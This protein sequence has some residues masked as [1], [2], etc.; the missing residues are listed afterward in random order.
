MLNGKLPYYRRAYR[1]VIEGSDRIIVH[2]PDMA[3][4]IHFYAKKR[5][6]PDYVYVERYPCFNARPPITDIGEAK[7]V[8]GVQDK[9]VLLAPGDQDVSTVIDALAR[10]P[11]E[12]VAV[13]AGAERRKTGG[14]V[15]H[16]GHVPPEHVSLVYGAADAVVFTRPEPGA[17]HA[18]LPYLKPVIVPDSPFSAEVEARY[19]AVLTYEGAGS[20]ALAVDAAIEH[21]QR[22]PIVE[23]ARKY[24]REVDAAT[25]A[26]HL[27][28]G[29]E[30]LLE[31]K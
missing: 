26:A 15:I 14:R 28:E 10:L 18:A 3:R 20:L 27:K 4:R 24:L 5:G 8:L 29:Y 16:L 31:M 17:V 9:K 25:L 23:G 13:F 22:R 21:H 7:T 11:D 1:S 12:Y 30:S 2:T 19:G 6:R